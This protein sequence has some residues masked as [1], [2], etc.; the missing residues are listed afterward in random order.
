[1]SS[2][3]RSSHRPPETPV[4]PRVGRHA[5]ESGFALLFLF[6]LAAFAAIALYREIPRVAFEGQRIREQDLIDRGEQYRRAVQLY[7]RKLK[8]YPPTVEALENTNNVRFLRKRYKDPMTGQ[9]EWRFIHVGP[10]GVF[11]DSLVHKP[12]GAEKK[13]ESGGQNTFITEGPAIGSM[14]E[15][16]SASVLPAALRLRRPSEG[17]APLP[18][19]EGSPLGGPPAPGQPE[20]PQAEAE[21][22]TE[23]ESLEAEEAVE[24]EQQQPGMAPVPFAPIQPGQ[25]AFPVGQPAPFQT[26]QP[27]QLS[28]FQ[29]QAPGQAYPFPRP[30]GSPLPGQ[31]QSPF[32]PQPVPGLPTPYSQP[33]Q[34]PGFQ[35]PSLQQP[36]GPVFGG[37]QPSPGAPFIGGAAPGP[38]QPGGFPGQGQNPA[39]ALIQRALT[40]PNPRAFEQFQRQAGAGPAGGPQIGGGIAGVASKLEAEG[41]KRYEDRSKYNEWEFVYDLKKDPMAMRGMMGAGSDQPGFGQ[42][43]GPQTGP[44]GPGRQRTPFPQTFPQ[45]G[46]GGP[47]PQQPR[48]VGPGRR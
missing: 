14:I 22:G 4:R 39:A 5:G 8:R 21:E 1:M 6:L 42:Q 27:G 26:T 19:A 3:C 29:Q 13:E 17:G 45:P 18:G 31:Q 38:G 28:P 33:L 46:P 48:P 35:P 20:Q 44:F 25:P 41:I 47:F 37:I 7:V 2:R 23:E 43:P 34:Q 9:E 40:T 11:L 32:P 24:P 16:G 30:P 15:T 36:G 12:P 10:G